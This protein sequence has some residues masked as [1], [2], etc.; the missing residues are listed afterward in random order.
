MYSL[1]TNTARQADDYS[2]RIAEIGRY[3]GTFT[4]AE[5]VLSKKGTQGIDFAFETKD[6]QSATFSIW[7]YSASGEELY[8]FRQLQA[9]MVCLRVKQLVPVTSTVKKWD[10]Q[11]K[12]LQTVQAEV[13]KE[14][15]NKPIGVLFETEEYERQDGSLGTKVVAAG[16]FDAQSELMASEIIDQ[17]VQPEKLAKRVASLKHRPLRNAPP[18]AQAA[19]AYKPV[20]GYQP[21]SA[22]GGDRD[23]DLDIPF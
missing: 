3:T 2:G 23:D 13:F 10:Y 6:K 19:P 21:Q 1:N 17:K 9:L 4:R 8:G 16:F 20:H 18:V 22:G 5:H 15:M 7:T 11:T 12:N 14:L